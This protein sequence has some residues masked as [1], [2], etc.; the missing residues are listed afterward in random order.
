MRKGRIMVNEQ[1]KVTVLVAIYNGEKY[2]GELLES[3]LS[4]SYENIR[5]ILSDDG[6]SDNSVDIIEKYAK[7]DNRVE[8]YVSGEKF[9]SAAAHFMHLI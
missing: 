6:S 4:G 3:I 9:G 2:L 5:V 8:R 1:K 7:E